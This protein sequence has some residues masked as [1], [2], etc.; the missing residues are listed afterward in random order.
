MNKY[1]IEVSGRGAECYVFPLTDEQLTKLKIGGIV[2][3]RMDMDEVYEILGIESVLDSELTYFGPYDD[4]DLHSIKVLG[5]NDELV[6]DLTDNWKYEIT[7]EDDY[8]SVHY[9]EKNLI[10]E[11]TCKGEFFKCVLEIE[12][13][14]DSSKLTPIITEVGEYVN[15]ITGL[16]YD[17]KVL[18]VTDY[19]DYWSKGF[20]FYLT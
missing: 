17:D 11:D 18:E 4:S 2:E 15:I 14:F 1:T 7:N 6:K 10:I 3:E 5:E 9:E 19:G 13:D 16:R 20:Y 8:V 12:G